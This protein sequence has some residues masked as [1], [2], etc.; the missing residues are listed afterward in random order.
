MD[1]FK[2]HYETFT[3]LG[4]M[5]TLLVTSCVWINTQFRVIDRQFDEV[6]KEIS[7]LKTDM[8]VMKTVM[9]MRDMMPKELAA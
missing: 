6:H 8:A 2:K 7:S 1:V 5:A 3:I 9:L 4:G